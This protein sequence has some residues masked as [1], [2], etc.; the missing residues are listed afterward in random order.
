MKVIIN[1]EDV[2]KGV[3]KATNLTSSKTGTAYL[4]AIWMEAKQ[5][6]IKIMS[7][8]SK[9]EFTGIYP[10]FVK[11]DGLVGILGKHFFELIKRLPSEEISLS[12]EKESLILE[13]GKR[14]YKLSIYDPSWFQEFSPFPEN[15]ILWSGDT[16]STIINKIF[17]CIGEEDSENLN[18]LE[19]APSGGEEFEACGLNNHQF[20]MIKFRD[21][22][23][24]S[25]LKKEGIL[26]AKSYLS[27]IKKW[28]ED[29]DIYVGV[30][31]NRL[32]LSN[33]EKTEHLSIPLSFTT[34]PDYTS[35]LS[36]F[37]KEEN[38]KMKLN[39]KEFMEALQRLLVFNTET[40]RCSYFS[41]KEKELIIYSHG[42]DVGEAM[43]ELEIEF[44]GDLERIV[45]PTKDLIEILN[46]FDSNYICVEFTNEE[47]P[48]KFYTDEEIDKNYFVVTMPVEISEEVYYTE[49]SVE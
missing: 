38:S 31:N 36:Y 15:L 47:G 2:L 30:E 7:T 22:A 11:E 16:F 28:L 5:D 1:K 25:I 32:F 37:E 49:E 19:I 39:R 8:D 42:H 27:E 33:K 9:L 44:S 34:F 29:E 35:F 20:A 24:S 13:Q 18:Y 41:F 23:F 26:I 14:K 21:K 3:Q 40:Q 4:K 17:F 12:L 6:Y 10:A 43:E 48:A 45:F 46:H